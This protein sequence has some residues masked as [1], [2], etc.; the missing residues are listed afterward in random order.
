MAVFPNP[1][2]ASFQLQL[3]PGNPAGASARVTVFNTLGAQVAAWRY[4]LTGGTNTFTIPSADW[5][6]GV[7]WIRTEIGGIELT[8]RL[9]VGRG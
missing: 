1:A 7:Y 6:A 5:P 2:G 9:A 4:D 3:D 8:A